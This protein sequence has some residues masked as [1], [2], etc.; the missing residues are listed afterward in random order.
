MRK[1]YLVILVFFTLVF[2]NGHESY[3]QGKL[4]LYEQEGLWGYAD[5]EGKVIIKPRFIIAN[6]FSSEGIAAVVDDDGWVYINTKGE[7]VVRPYVF[8]NGPDYFREGLARFITD[9][10]FGFFD[11][12]GKVIIE[13]Q[14][15]FA[16]PFHEGLAAICMDCKILQ[17]DEEHSTVVGGKW[18]YINKEGKIVVPL[19]F[20]KAGILKMRTP[21][22]NKARG[23]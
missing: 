7:N 9:N 12:T 8:D 22:G 2:I 10:K 3:A 16:L 4:S 5:K 1:H 15:D 19:I 20:D 13:A 6:D 14:F 11:K 21:E 18:G 23:Q 17:T